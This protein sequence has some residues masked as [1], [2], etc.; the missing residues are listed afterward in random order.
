[1]EEEHK[2]EQIMQQ[3]VDQ[4]EVE[5]MVVEH[6]ELVV[7]EVTVDQEV[8]MD[9]QELVVVAVENLQQE[10]TVLEVMLE[11][12]EVVTLVQLQEVQ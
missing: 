6:Q 3:V 1:V 4:V 5:I 11:Q 9:L 8:D 2:L 12:V 10:A 7:K